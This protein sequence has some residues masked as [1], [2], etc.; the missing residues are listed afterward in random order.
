MSVCHGDWERSFGI[1]G[2]MTYLRPSAR[3]L[4]YPLDFTIEVSEVFCLL[5]FNIVLGE[6]LI[7][8]TPV[9]PTLLTVGQ[10]AWMDFDLLLNSLRPYLY[11]IHIPSWQVERMIEDAQTDLYY[12]VMRLTT[13]LHVVRGIKM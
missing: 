10:L 1:L 11:S 6:A 8:I 4:T 12:P 7:L 2:H 13:R 9:D 3:K 5:F